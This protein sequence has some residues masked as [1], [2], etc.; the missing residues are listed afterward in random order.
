MEMRWKINSTGCE[1]LVNFS[2]HVHSCA[3]FC[4]SWYGAVYGGLWGSI[5]G[6]WHMS[7]A[8]PLPYRCKVER[9][10]QNVHMKR[11]NSN[12][13]DW[14]SV[15]TW[16]FKIPFPSDHCNLQWSSFHV[17]IASEICEHSTVQTW[18]FVAC[19]CTLDQQFLQ[20][21]S[22]WDPSS[23]SWSQTDVVFTFSH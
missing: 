3:Q 21:H 6:A 10:L 18:N 19:S 23:C 5:Q 12:F 20:L 16:R 7:Y 8:S 11:K 14:C 17:S 13:E 1:M 4:K 2:V 15:S 22:H 9:N